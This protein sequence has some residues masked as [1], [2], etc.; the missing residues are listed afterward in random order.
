MEMQE[1][2]K[3]EN[4]RFVNGHII[5]TKKNA[6]ASPQKWV[7]KAR[8][9]AAGNRIWNFEGKSTLDDN[10]TMFP[11]TLPAIRT[12]IAATLVN[13]GELEQCDLDNAYLH[14]QLEGPS[15]Y[16]TLPPQAIPSEWKELKNPVVQLKKAL[17]G[18][19][20]AGHDWD[21]YAHNLL[22]QDGWTPLL[23]VEPR[24]YVRQTEDGI[25]ILVLYVD[26]IILGGKM[27]KKHWIRIEVLFKTKT[28]ERINKFVGINFEVIR[29]VK[30]NVL[31]Q[32]ND[33][34]A[35]IVQSFE[36]IL[37]VKHLPKLHTYATALEPAVKA[38]MEVQ[39]KGELHVECKSFV[40]AILYLARGS[41]PDISYAVGVLGSKVD[42]WT[43]CDNQLRRIMGYL[44]KT[45]MMTLYGG[46]ET[47][48][49]QRV[50]VVSDSDFAGC[51]A[52]CLQPQSSLWV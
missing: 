4:A 19:P 50:I 28:V 45:T 46:I 30:D 26:D 2:R 38:D 41:R 5:Y 35:T 13:G 16:I 37:E 7:P 27:L 8:L 1:A 34:C 49:D 29:K 3:V 31:I 10:L 6:E 11:V 42:K 14:A 24:I 40:G 22:V 44:K 33:F 25:V 20:R 21:K 52:N 43:V 23:E 39:S 36:E 47:S 17:Y 48:Q 9:V 18:L 15:T 12:A 51:H 32:Q